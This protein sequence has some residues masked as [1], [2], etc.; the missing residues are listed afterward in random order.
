MRG[1][2][3]ET[4]PTNERA[5]TPRRE[6]RRAVALG[7][8]AAAI[9]IAVAMLFS[10][11]ASAASGGGSTTLTAPY[12]GSSADA[13]FWSTAGC[14]GTLT[15]SELPDFNASSGTF[16]GHLSAASKSC[17]KTTSSMFA[18]ETG[19]FGT[20]SF[21][22]STNGTY[23]IAASW[24]L[25]FA[26]DITHHARSSGAA[27]ASVVVG[28]WAVLD[29]LTNGSSWSVGQSSWSSGTS[30]HG[31]WMNYSQSENYNGSFSLVVGH[32]YELVTGVYLEVDSWSTWNG[33]ARSMAAVNMG[34]APSDAVLTSIVIA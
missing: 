4:E 25:G 34:A 10:P 8:A 15:L 21:Q 31:A 11:A 26:V 14:G 13:A 6:S 30:T 17:G 24:T 18:E 12:S 23:M 16:T 33:H 19:D 29:D 9:F 5:P 7:T 27:G 20:N 28:S 22:V 1:A 32:L 3:D 2:S